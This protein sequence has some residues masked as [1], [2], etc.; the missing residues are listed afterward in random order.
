MNEEQKIKIKKNG[1]YNNIEL[2]DITPDNNFIIIEKVFSEGKEFP[3]KF[4]EG[5]HT[6]A[7]RAKYLGEDVS[8]WLKQEEHDDYKL[9]GG[10]G[11]KVKVFRYE[12]KVMNPK[13]KLNMLIP[14]LR[15]EKA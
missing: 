8:F 14:K 2:K 4:R 1:N 6:Y 15:F 11:D 9:L 10:E 12:K 7:C 3:D 13:T 5:K